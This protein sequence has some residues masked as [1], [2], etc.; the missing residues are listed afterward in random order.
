MK[1][2]KTSYSNLCI[3]DIRARLRTFALERQWDKFHSPKNLSMALMVE[4]AELAE[5]FQWLTATES[6]NLAGP[7]RRQVEEEV[8]DVF[9]YLL[10]LA[11]KM[12]IDLLDAANRKIAI[13]AVKYPAKKVRGSARKYSAY[14]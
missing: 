8:A 7:V 2:A 12:N 11:D 1:S 4:A 14:K 13:N 9:L 6:R 5:H 10:R 3:E